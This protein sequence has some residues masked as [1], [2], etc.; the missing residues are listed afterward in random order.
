MSGVR[1]ILALALGL[2]AGLGSKELRQQA[3]SRLAQSQTHCINLLLHLHT[4]CP[5]VVTPGALAAL[6]LMTWT[7]MLCNLIQGLQGARPDP[8]PPEP[9]KCQ[10]S[11]YKDGLLLVQGRRVK[12]LGHQALI[13]VTMTAA[14]NRPAL[15]LQML[16][17]AETLIQFRTSNKAC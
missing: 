5:K 4:M 8:F 6:I 12:G 7:R 2:A 10:A 11:Q 13:T 16:T 17:I 3:L 1:L 15:A 14:A 9:S